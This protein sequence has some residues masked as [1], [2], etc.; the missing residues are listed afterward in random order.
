MLNRCLLYHT[1]HINTLCGQS[2]EFAIL[3]LP[4]KYS[5]SIEEVIVTGGT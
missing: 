3:K 2:A 1:K 5:I 4:V